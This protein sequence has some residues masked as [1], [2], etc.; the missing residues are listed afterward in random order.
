MKEQS[1]FYFDESSMN[2]GLS[3]FF[4]INFIENVYGL[5]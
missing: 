1:K 2:L 3:S 4:K 5:L